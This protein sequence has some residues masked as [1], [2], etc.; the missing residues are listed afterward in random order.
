MSYLLDTNVVS[1][2]VASRPN[3]NV[4]DWL[5]AVDAEQVF[6]SVITVGELKGELRDL[7]FAAQ[8]AAHQLVERGPPGSLRRT[9]SADRHP[10]RTRLGD[11]GGRDA[12]RRN[13]DP[14]D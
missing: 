6:L 12:C 13:S 8:A 11:L 2:L 9:R 10:G 3:A 4:V 14:G 5:D 1:E 7:R